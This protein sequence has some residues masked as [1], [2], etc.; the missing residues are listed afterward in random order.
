[1]L[2]ERTSLTS[3]T[4][5]NGPVSA[6]MPGARSPSELV[7]WASCSSCSR[8]STHTCCPPLSVALTA[9]AAPEKAEDRGTMTRFAAGAVTA[10][11]APAGSTASWSIC[12]A[13]MPRL[14]ISQ[15]E[16]PRLMTEDKSLYC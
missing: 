2:A 4:P 3:S 10:K 1:M 11:T 13:E 16:I 9:A 12:E 14:G 5:Y 7:R 6:V 8:Y 15:P